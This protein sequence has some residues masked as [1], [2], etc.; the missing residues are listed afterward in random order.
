MSF[1][2]DG[3]GV[4]PLGVYG[5]GRHKEQNGNEKP[6]DEFHIQEEF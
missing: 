1:S 6:F 4:C 2:Q 5:D 3:L